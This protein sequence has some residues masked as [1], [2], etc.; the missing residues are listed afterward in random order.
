MSYRV[1][2][3]FFADA[4]P[5]PKERRRTKKERRN[6]FFLKEKHNPDNTRRYR[7]YVDDA[8]L[9]IMHVD[10]LVAY[11]KF[12]NNQCRCEVLWRS[13]YVLEV[14]VQN[15]INDGDS[16][17]RLKKFPYGWREDFRSWCIR[18][19][20]WRPVYYKHSSKNVSDMKQFANKHVRHKGR[21]FL[22]DSG[23]EIAPTEHGWYKKVFCSYDICDF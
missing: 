7:G 9:A 5:E 1:I 3:E 8:N 20:S 4:E 13:E 23:E 21:L 6:S 12:E 2:D 16:V 15:K 10:A 17:V 18:R 22:R 11:G 14:Y 19:S